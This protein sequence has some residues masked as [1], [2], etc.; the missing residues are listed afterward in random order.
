[1]SDSDS[2]LVEN[3]LARPEVHQ[4]W[5]GGYRTE[6]NER[7]YEG[8]FDY[9]LEV[10]KPPPGATILD[11]GCGP[12]AHSARLARRGFRV[13]AVDFSESALRMAEEYVRE[14]S[15]QDKIKLGRES[16]LGLSFPDESFDYVLCWGVLMHIPE[17]GRAVAELARVVKPGGTLVVSE[18]NQSSLEA[19]G[20]RGLK[21]ALKRE[22]A[23]VKETEAGV[24][25]W[26][27]SGDDALVTRQAN[28][29]W[30]VRSFGERGLRL[31]KRVAGQF[32][33][34][35]TLVSA[36]PLRKL[37]HGFN[38]FWFRHVKLPGLAFGNI[39]FLRK[40]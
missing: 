32:S 7:F 29:E 13:H 34:A 22:R 35:Y 33:E 30:L 2:K 38:K 20:V 37:I 15:L 27:V 23:E 19:V 31:T 12:C 8:A 10:L 18:A 9:I 17:V 6:E 16:L 24:E 14:R 28:I 36:A 40:G 26:K 25:Y 21:R 1:M 5:E 3:L 4:K 39:L 11:V